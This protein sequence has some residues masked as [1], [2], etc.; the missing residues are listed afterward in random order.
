MKT[1]KQIRAIVNKATD[2]SFKD[3][4]LQE[5]KV[6]TFIKLF[7]SQ[8]RTEAIKL[9]AEYMKRLRLIINSTTMIVE[10]VIPLSQK[11]KTSLKKKFSSSFKIQN[12]QYRLNPSLLGGLRV[13]IGDYISEDSIMSRINQIGEAIRG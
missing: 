9:L 6:L 3:G 11:D 2:V 12:T 4:K 13:R 8:S 7:K 5:G 10:S 1:S